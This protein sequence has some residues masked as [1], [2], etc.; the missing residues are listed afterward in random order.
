MRVLKATGAP[1]AFEVVDNIVDRVTPE[2]IA[3]LKRTGCG[4]KGEFVTGIGR[5]TLPSIN[6]DIRK[7]L[8]VRVCR[9]LW[10]R[11]AAA[12]AARAHHPP[13]PP[14]P[15]TRSSTRTLCT[16]STSPASPRGTLAWTL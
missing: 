3:S 2:A 15:A 12:A 4:L 7:T 14:P 6:I 11:R 13:P 1:I 16:R 9:R 5:G 10:L 8:N